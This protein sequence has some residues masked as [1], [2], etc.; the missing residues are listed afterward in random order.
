VATNILSRSQLPIYRHYTEIPES[1]TGNS[2]L[3]NGSGD[4][5]GSSSVLGARQYQRLF[6]GLKAKSIPI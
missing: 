5:H 3:A 2:S 1:K 4:R 6:S